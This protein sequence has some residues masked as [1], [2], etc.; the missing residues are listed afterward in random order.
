MQ[1]LT[2]RTNCAEL[3]CRPALLCPPFSAIDRRSASGTFRR[4]R[5][6]RTMAVQLGYEAWVKGDPK[7]KTLG[8]CKQQDRVLVFVTLF[9]CESVFLFRAGPFCHRALLALEEKHAKYTQ[10]YVDFA[11]KPEWCVP[12]RLAALVALLRSPSRTAQRVPSR[13]RYQHRTKLLVQMQ[14]AEGQS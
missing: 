11:E 7:T 1:Q 9:C 4:S 5:P 6:V 8:D 14:A 12:G 10:D 2:S 13:L 3:W